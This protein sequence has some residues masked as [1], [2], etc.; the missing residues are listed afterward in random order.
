MNGNIEVINENL[1][2]V[3][4]Q[5]LKEGY[6]EELKLI[7]NT[8][9]GQINLSNTGKIILDSGARAYPALKKLF[10]TCMKK[11]NEELMKIMNMPAED[12]VDELCKNIVGW[13][14]K[15]RVIEIEYKTSQPETPFLQKI[16]VKLQIKF[17]IWIRK[18]V[19]KWHLFKQE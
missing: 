17:L 5:Y 12:S 7:P 10:S 13:E 1:W 2:A 16:K 14:L 15:R 18:K 9:C 19:E 11:T 8:E 3:N 6:I 4:M